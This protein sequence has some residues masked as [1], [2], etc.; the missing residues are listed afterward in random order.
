MSRDALKRACDVVGGQKPLA[1]RIGT[2][3]SMVW[4]WLERAKRGVPAEYVLAIERETGVPRHELRP[5][6]F[7]GR[8]SARRRAAQSAAS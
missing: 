5:D 6:I 8:S 7:A 2:S 4:Y 3:Q 1:E